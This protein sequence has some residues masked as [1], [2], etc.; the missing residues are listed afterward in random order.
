MY[1]KLNTNEIL[2]KH[3]YHGKRNR[4]ENVVT[5]L[6]LINNQIEFNI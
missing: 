2:L 3:Y 5:G 1:V 6:I 4:Y